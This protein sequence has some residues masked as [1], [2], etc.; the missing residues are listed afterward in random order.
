MDEEQLHSWYSTRAEQTYRLDL[1]IVDRATGGVVGE[2]VLNEWEPANRSCNFRTLIGP[3]G[4]SRGLGTETTRLIVDHGFR[5]LG[6]HRIELEVYS[7]NPRARRV[8]DKVGFVHEGTRRDALRFDDEWIDAEVMA[9][10]ATDWPVT[11]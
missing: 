11:A 4:R 1:A 6:L 10:L 9:I 5:A 2:V 7:F 8:Y 3:T